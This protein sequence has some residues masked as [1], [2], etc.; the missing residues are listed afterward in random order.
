MTMKVVG[1]WEAAEGG[2]DAAVVFFDVANSPR[3]RPYFIFL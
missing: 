3:K 2:W 1:T